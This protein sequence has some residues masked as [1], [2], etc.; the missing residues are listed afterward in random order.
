MALCCGKDDMCLGEKKER[1]L[2]RDGTKTMRKGKKRL[3]AERWIEIE[4]IAQDRKLW[5]N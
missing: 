2:H 5:Q 1:R 3:A 4:M